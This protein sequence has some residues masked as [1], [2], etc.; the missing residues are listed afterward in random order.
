MPGWVHSKYQEIE[1]MKY[2]KVYTLSVTKDRIAIQFLYYK[3]I[4]FILMF[5]VLFTR[6]KPWSC[7]TV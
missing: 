1:C 4:N 6:Q 7:V 5:A 3:G 2:F